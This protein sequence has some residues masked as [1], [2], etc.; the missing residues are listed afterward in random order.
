MPDTAINA[1]VQKRLR[2][3]EIAWITTVRRD[4]QPQPVPVWFLWEARA[5]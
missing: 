2:E 1:R 5:S 3:E 4:G